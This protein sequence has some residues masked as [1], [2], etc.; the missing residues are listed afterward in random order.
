[1][2]RVGKVSITALN[3]EYWVIWTEDNSGFQRMDV[4]GNMSDY[5]VIDTSNCV[6]AY[7]YK[8]KE[9]HL[10]NEEVLKYITKIRNTASIFNGT[11][12]T[13]IEF[14]DGKVYTIS[15]K[16]D[17]NVGCKWRRVLEMGK[18]QSEY[19]ETPDGTL[20]F[21]SI[22]DTSIS[23]PPINLSEYIIYD[24]SASRISNT[25]SSA[26]FY[27]EEYLRAVY[28]ID[29]LDDNDFV[30]IG[31]MEE[32]EE[33][34]RIF[35]DAPTKVK[36]IDLE[37]TG[38]ETGMY[39]NDVI[40]GV[41]LS[42]NEKESTYYPFRQEKFKY[43]LPISFL[44]KILDVVNNQPKDVVIVAYNAK[45]EI[46]GVWKES[47]HYI[48][49]SEY[50]KAWDADAEEHGLDNTYLRIDADPMFDSIIVN[51]V[52][53]QKG[54]HTLKTEAYKADGKFYLELSHVFKDPKNIRF[55][56]LTEN[57]VRLYACPDGP[58]AI[59]V[60]KR[61]N[62]LIPKKQQYISQLESS[63]IYVTAE[64]EFFGMRTEKELLAKLIEN[65]RYI[66]NMLADYFKRIHKTNKNINSPEVKREIFYNVLRCPVEVRT[67]TGLP[68]TSN[69][70]LKRIIELGTKREVDTTKEYKD[71]VDLNG[72][73]IVEGKALA[74]NR[75]PSLVILEAY[76]KAQKRLGAYERIQRTSLRDR[77]MFYMNQ[78]GAA[79]GRRTSDA[80]QYSDGMKQLI[81][82]DSKDHYLWSADWKQIEL[83]V[84][85]YL[86]KQKDLIELESNPNIDIHRAITHIITKQ[87]IWAISAKER[88]RRKRTNFGVVYGMSP[89]GL[90]KQNAGPAYTNDDLVDAT[91]SINDFMGG[92]PYV[93]AFING[94]KKFIEENGYIE[95][96]FGRRREFKEI[97][98]PTY[99]EKKKGS[100]LKAGNNMPVQGFAADM[101]KIVELKVKQYIKDKGWDELVECDGVWLPKV[102]MMLSIHDEILVSTHK[103]IPIA[104]IITMFKVCMEL[105]IDGA[106]PFFAA[107]AL[108][109]N[110]LDG[111]NDAYELDL[112][113][114][115]EIVEAYA[116]D[117]TELIHPDT[118]LQELNEYRAKRLGEYMNG[119]IAEYKTPEAVA[120][121]VRDD[122]FT[123]TLI[124][125][126]IKKHE[127]FEH[128]DAILEATKRYMAKGHIDTCDIGQSKSSDG[129]KKDDSIIIRSYEELEDMVNF[130]ENG[131]AIF[132]EDSEEAKDDLDTVQETSMYARVAR[133]WSVYSMDQVFIDLNDFKVTDER[134]QEVY[135]DM[136]Q[137][138]EPDAAYS[139]F[140]MIDG[141]I[142]PVGTK[143]NYCP[144]KIDKIVKE[145]ME[146]SGS[147]E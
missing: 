57:I 17:G 135:Q 145:V 146:R 68:S 67:N 143:M 52:F 129:D 43:N 123:H 77:V 51:P 8:N 18:M 119:L 84:L 21:S 61:L 58:N 110:W 128:M 49:Y 130:D 4:I 83:R 23:I 65:E 20:D 70:A 147:V 9:M 55:N 80:H 26:E 103:S 100:I 34:L 40:T 121:H 134:V 14:K 137:L 144:D 42:W 27:S 35:G 105:R 142:R 64:N 30:V 133:T 92:L 124:S 56:V 7:Y 90:A 73:V 139:V 120:E 116:K 50:A 15:T 45:F 96:K 81:V 85:A 22:S 28:P 118:Y 48:K 109:S 93:N 39:G 38:T 94:N 32:A 41:V 88:S 12:N 62:G 5:N 122:E 54:A 98:D 87:P 112:V 102:R 31:S 19:Y 89:F 125:V 131:E 25:T 114:R 3:C 101:L 10:G 140:F 53:K 113:F 78:Y 82:A 2:Q 91:E 74:S 66:V 99:P 63:M 6:A 1:M 60:Y 104:E 46:E 16:E 108:V 59:K 69:I 115:D 86:S 29:H 37:T 71:I 13:Q 117:G 107:P 127:K 111:K 136:I 47:K 106:P 11:L 36:A 75:Y 79:T 126:E 95:T 44:A 72:K 24:V 132:D 141:V 76:A 97:L 138:Y 33:R